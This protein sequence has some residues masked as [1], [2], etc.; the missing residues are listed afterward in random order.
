MH[1]AN[2][3]DAIDLEAKIDPKSGLISTTNEKNDSISYGISDKGGLN[4][5]NSAQGLLNMILQIILG[6]AGLV[7]FG[8]VVYGGITIMFNTKGDKAIYSKSVKI[9]ITGAIAF[10][11]VS[12]S[13]VVTN[14]V[15]NYVD[16]IA[17]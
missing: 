9:M 6:F 1:I 14:F 13:Y 4:T 15:L 7:S 11:I 2:A 16:F 8:F 5:R 12:L 3:D 17:K 10:L